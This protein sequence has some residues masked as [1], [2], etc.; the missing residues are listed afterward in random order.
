MLINI[1]N[2]TNDTRWEE[3][4]TLF[5]ELSNRTSSTVEQH[6]KGIVSVIFV[7]DSQIQEINK[8]YRGI[9][10]ATDV[11]SFALQ[12]SEDE[13]EQMG[14]EDELGDIFINVNA[15]I[16]QAEEYA[17]SVK[18]E[19]CFLFVHGL[20]HLLGYDHMNEKEAIQMFQLQDV[21]LD[22]IVS[23]KMD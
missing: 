6:E 18:R 21:I 12:D 11:I 9:D 1:V 17:H 8:L 3:Y 7:N 19:C 13:Y 16:R 15:V 4:K 22:E 20:L 10:K 23:R 14:D 5:F 2:N